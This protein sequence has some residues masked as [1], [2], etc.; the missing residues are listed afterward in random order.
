MSVTGRRAMD[1]SELDESGTHQPQPSTESHWS[2]VRLTVLHSP[3]RP[4]KNGE[5]ARWAELG[6]AV[7]GFIFV[8]LIFVPAQLKKNQVWYICCHATILFST[9]LSICF[10]YWG[11]THIKM[12]RFL[13][14]KPVFAQIV[15][16]ALLDWLWITI[17]P[18]LGWEVTDR[19]GA[20]TGLII[21]IGF[22]CLDSLKSVSRWYRLWITFFFMFGNMFAIYFAYFLN[23]AQTLLLIGATNTT[24]TTS[25]VQESVAT[26]LVTLTAA[27]LVTIWQDEGFQYSA[28]YR[29]YL[30]K[31]A[32]ETA[33]VKPGSAEI[34]LILEER[35]AAVVAWRGWPRKAAV[36]YFASVMFYLSSIMLSGKTIDYDIDGRESTAMLVLRG[37]AVMLGCGGACGFFFKN[38]SWRRFKYTFTSTQGVIWMFYTLV[39]ASAGLSR[40]SGTASVSS[41]LG[42]LYTTLGFT[43]WLSLESV[44]QISRL[45]H[46]S[47]TIIVSLT[48]VAS[49][50][51][52]AYAWKDDVVLG[53]LNGVE[54]PGIVTIY[55]IQR[56]CYINMLLLMGGS[57]AT[58]ATKNLRDNSYFVLVTG[59]VLRREILELESLS[60]D[61]DGDDDLIVGHHHHQ[62]HLSRHTTANTK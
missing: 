4:L 37:T 20:A 61:P 47:I 16:L 60:V 36:V 42:T 17:Q 10:K 1:I 32:V 53:D 3:P 23:P 8:A 27:M 31:L 14:G 15:L 39:Y 43:L 9:T 38:V 2:R 33:G 35:D 40:P 50:Y 13:S 58:I 25:S 45:M 34:D 54:V 46:T 24:V 7:S 12:L 59:N 55:S 57:L 5:P 6:V 26:T 11:N 49:I 41:A 18:D 30:P 56:T 62:D 28:L 19:I 21:R 52:S 51:L 22:I 44:K 48:L 29:S